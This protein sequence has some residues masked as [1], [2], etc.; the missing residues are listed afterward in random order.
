[1][2]NILRRNPF[3]FWDSFP[4]VATPLSASPII[5]SDELSMPFEASGLS[6]AKLFFQI[7][8]CLMDS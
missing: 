4:V 2:P 5:L 3:S 1:M 6:T 7:K 8:Y